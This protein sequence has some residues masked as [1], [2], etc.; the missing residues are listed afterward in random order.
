MLYKTFL[1]GGKQIDE[2]K[3]KEKKKRERKK[4][5]FPKEKGI[6]LPSHLIPPLPS[7]PMDIQ[8]RN[9]DHDPKS[10]PG[11][12]ETTGRD[13]R[14]EREKKMYKNVAYKKVQTKILGFPK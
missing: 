2:K 9:Q 5:T 13:M 12:D 3:K 14:K 11:R 1:G 10:L 8:T 7:Q 6:A 4:P